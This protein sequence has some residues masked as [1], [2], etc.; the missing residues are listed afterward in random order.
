MSFTTIVQAKIFPYL[1]EI[2]L[3]IFAN[4]KKA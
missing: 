4:T 2:S 3:E 1:K